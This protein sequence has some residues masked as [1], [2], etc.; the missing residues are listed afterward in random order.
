MADDNAIP[1]P[2]NPKKTRLG[3]KKYYTDSEL[4]QIIE[5]SDLDEFDYVGGDSDGGDGSD[6]EEG[7]DHVTTEAVNNLSNSDE[8][9]PENFPKGM[10]Q[11][12]NNLI[13]WK[14][15]P[16]DMKK[17]TFLKSERLLIPP[18]GNSPID[19]FR[20]I[21]TDNFLQTIVEETNANAVEIFLSGTTTEKSRICHWKNLTLD[22]LL[23]FLGVL[24]HMGNVKLKRF[25]DYWK[26]DPLFHCKAIADNMSRNRF[27]IILRSLHFSRNP[28]YGDPNP[29]DRLYKIRPVIDFFNQ[30]MAEIY[31]PCQQLSLDESMVLWRGRLSFRQYIKNKKHKYGIKLYI[32][33]TPSG[34][35][36][37]IAVYTGM[38]DEIGGR[39]HAK[40]VV[41]HLMENKFNVG[42]HLYMDNYYNSFDLAK[43]LLDRGTHCTGTLRLDRKNVP[44]DVK[45]AKLVKGHTISRYA[46]GVMIGKWRDKREVSYLSTEF[47]NNMIEI[48]TKRKE[49]VNKP[50]PI[51]QYNKYMSGID[52]QDQ[53]LSY[54][55][56]ERKTIR[57]PKKLFMHF[58]EMMLL[59]AHHL[60]N[61]YSGSKM[62]L[63]DFRINV[64]KSLMPRITQDI[65]AAVTQGHKLVKRD[66]ADGKKQVSRKRCQSCTKMGKRTQTIYECSTCPGA[67]GFCLDCSDII[68]K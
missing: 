8:G 30:R 41:L 36:L 64:I 55:S 67:P 3:V 58:I 54:Y 42:H 11:N 47:E 17:F 5:N 25:Q 34:L 15:D 57:W 12:K 53:M 16:T 13:D 39:G 40:K 10:T 9:R 26:K 49:K 48:E 52:R 38:L 20:H 37:M 44:I 21:V 68:H 27:L 50:L 1:G 24:L 56:A 22:E 32:L 31:Y 60:F 59:N 7:N 46:E 63:Y 28:T 19:Y 62:T 66:L 23:V 6:Y 18:N 2:S 35:I 33:T 14:V 4:L 61:K 51:V 43:T 45:T 29:E 65:P